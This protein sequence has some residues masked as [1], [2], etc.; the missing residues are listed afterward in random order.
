VWAF[1]LLSPYL[2]PSENWIVVLLV[3]EG[4]FF[5]SNNLA[6]LAGKLLLLAAMLDLRSGVTFSWPVDAYLKW[7]LFAWIVT[8]WLLGRGPLKREVTRVEFAPRGFSEGTFG[9]PWLTP[10]RPEFGDMGYPTDHQSCT[11]QSSQ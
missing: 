5:Q 9:R 7:L 4:S 2:L 10:R 3:V 6:L 8:E 11:P 1:L